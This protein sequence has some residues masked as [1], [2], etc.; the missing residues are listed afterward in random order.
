VQQPLA[1]HALELVFSLSLKTEARTHDQVD[2]RA[3]DE[4]LTGF[5]HPLNPL[6]QMDRDTGHVPSPLLDL[7][8][9]QPGPNLEAQLTHGVPDRNCTLN[10]AGGPVERGEDTVAGSLHEM[11]TKPREL[12]INR[13]I[14]QVEA[15]PPDLVPE[16][17]GLL[18]RI[19]D[20]RE[21]NRGEESS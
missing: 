15:V 6:C 20:V 2:H 16:S 1:G 7:T 5:S 12:P 13:P 19:D 3:R 14:V 9:V 11:S 8:C 10:G 18:G 4:D 21:E 17:G